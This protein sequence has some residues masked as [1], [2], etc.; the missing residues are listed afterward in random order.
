MLSGCRIMYYHV[1]LPVCTPAFDAVP[2]ETTQVLPFPLDQ[3]TPATTV[4]E[5]YASDAVLKAHCLVRER[6]S[7]REGERGRERELA[8]IIGELASHRRRERDTPPPSHRGR[9]N[10]LG[11]YSYRSR[12]F[13]KRS[14]GR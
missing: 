4:V 5:A 7:E 13:L 12:T 8:D 9:E 1:R 14:F 6:E 3:L 10:V 11:K 2:I